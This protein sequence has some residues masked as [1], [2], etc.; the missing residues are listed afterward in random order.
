L[1][2][3]IY[4]HPVLV[5]LASRLEDG[6]ERSVLGI[7]E[8]SRSH[9]IFWPSNS[10]RG[11]GFY[12]SRLD[13]VSQ[14]PAEESHRTRRCSHAASHDGFAAQLSRL[15]AAISFASDHIF[16]DLIDIRL[17]DVLHPP[18]PDQ[19][20][21]MPADSTDIADNGC[22]LLWS[23]AFA[24]DQAGVQ[25]FKIEFAQLFD[26]DGFVIELPLF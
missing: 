25:I 17:G 13:G 16:Q 26:R 22:R 9:V 19:R 18:R 4:G 14:Y 21:D 6:A 24:H 12:D 5:V 1:P 23:P 2:N 11:V 20:D 10:V 15:E 8:A 7:A 3:D